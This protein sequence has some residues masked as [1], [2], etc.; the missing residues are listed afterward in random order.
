[1]NRRFVKGGERVYVEP[2]DQEAYCVASTDPPS[3]AL[4]SGVIPIGRCNAR[5]SALFKEQADNLSIAALR[6]FMDGRSGTSMPW[7]NIS[8]TLDQEARRIGMIVL[9]RVE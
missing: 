7:V 1:M 6:R 2:C 8:A 4:C 5:I 9:D 3:A